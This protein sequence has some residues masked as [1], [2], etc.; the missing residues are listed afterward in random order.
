MVSSL[1][2]FIPRGR[3]RPV[4]LAL[5]LVDPSHRLSASNVAEVALVYFDSSVLV[6]LVVE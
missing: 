3:Q 2:Q 6:K 1:G 5:D 4:D